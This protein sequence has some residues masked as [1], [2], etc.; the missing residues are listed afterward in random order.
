VYSCNAL[1]KRASNAIPSAIA[2]QYKTPF[3]SSR[4]FS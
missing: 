4:S 1:H 2:S 3:I